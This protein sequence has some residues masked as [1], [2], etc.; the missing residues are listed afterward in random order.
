M[1]QNGFIR[2]T[3]F[4]S[5]WERNTPSGNFFSPAIHGLFLKNNPTASS[6]STVPD[7]MPAAGLTFAVLPD[8]LLQGN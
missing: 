2:K 6:S 1:R 3:K 8:F 7:A 4:I 5:K